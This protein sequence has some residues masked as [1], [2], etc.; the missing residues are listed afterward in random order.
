[1]VTDRPP[2]VAAGRL[3][4][5]EQARSV[6]DQHVVESLPRRDRRVGRP[7]AGV[8]KTGGM[9]LANDLAFA[10]RIEVTPY[11]PVFGPIDVDQVGDSPRLSD[12]LVGVAA[13]RE[14]GVVDP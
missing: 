7:A 8:P 11:H 3:V 5:V 1:M 13:R 10:G 9:K 6:G 4:L 12:S 2:V 14:V